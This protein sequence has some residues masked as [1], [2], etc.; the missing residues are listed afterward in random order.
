M[1]DVMN[2]PSLGEQLMMHSLTDLQLNEGSGWYL[3][4]VN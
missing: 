1:T 3:P 2:R 4:G